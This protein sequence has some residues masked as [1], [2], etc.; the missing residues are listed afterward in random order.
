MPPR[1][2]ASNV[3]EWE[4]STCLR[5]NPQRRMTGAAGPPRQ[6]ADLARRIISAAVLAVALGYI[7]ASLVVYLRHLIA[8]IRQKHFP[9]AVMEQLPLLSPGHL[10]EA[11]QQFERLLVVEVAREVSPLVV[12]L[13]MAWGLRRRRGELAAFFMLGFG[14]WDIFYYLFL[15]VLMGWPASLATWDVLYLIPT[16]W[17]APVWA[18]MVVAA[19]LALAGLAVLLGGNVRRS[20]LALAA[21][22]LIA[23]GAGLVLSSF[24]L[25]TG[26]A[27]QGVPARFDWGW[28][29][30]GWVTAVAG[31]MWLLWP[32]RGSG[33]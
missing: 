15:K 13:A 7:E 6:R 20:G 19:T 1:R 8:P 23:L 21:W 30:A 28:F 9:Q 33:R 27:F 4:M 11:G 29:L 32:V 3:Y 25:R 22:P 26:E 17:V 12:L 16:A 31:L 10:S 5:E 14:L 2:P 18:P 24:F